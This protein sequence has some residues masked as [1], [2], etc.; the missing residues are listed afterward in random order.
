VSGEDGAAS[1][2]A[3]RSGLRPTP[4]PTRRF[5]GE[6]LIDEQSRPAAPEP[7]PDV[8]FTARGRSAG[9]HLI[10]VHEGYR[11]EMVEVRAALD[12]VRRGAAELGPMDARAW[13]IGE[14]RTALQT[15]ALRANDW[16]LGGYCQAQCLSLTQHHGMEDDGIFP[17]L[18]RS[19]PDL[20]PVL[21]QL[22]AEHLVIHDVLER[23]DAALVHLAQHPDDYA[24]ISDAVDLLTDTI[25]SHFAYEERELVA[26]LSRFG[27]YPGQL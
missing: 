9:A 3:R 19:Q 24:P 10:A 26:P 1:W 5:S 12:T 25:T 16:A 15:M 17:H 13:D 18:R 6:W 14:A 22:A 21:D 4:A 27:F 2:V 7:D 23:I 11:A 20:A 8:E